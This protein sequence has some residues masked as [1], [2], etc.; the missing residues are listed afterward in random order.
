MSEAKEEVKV[1]EEEKKEETVPKKDFE[2]LGKLYFQNQVFIFDA[3]KTLRDVGHNLI[4]MGS[5]IQELLQKNE[6]I[7][8]VAVSEVLA[9]MNRQ[10]RQA[11]V[12]QSQPQK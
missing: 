3:Y 12:N 6:Q 10:Q 11:Q 4:Q 5:T 8:A 1:V 9:R 2:D 7:T